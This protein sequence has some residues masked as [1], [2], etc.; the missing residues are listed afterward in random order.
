MSSA[1][2]LVVDDDPDLVDFVSKALEP[3]QLTIE[4]AGSG[5]AALSRV[6]QQAPELML[7][8]LVLPGIDGLETLRQLRREGFEF[9][10]VL[11]TSHGG[12]ETTI[13]AMEEGAWDYL[14]KPLHVAQLTTLVERCLRYTRRPNG[15]GGLSDDV[16]E[17]VLL[18]G[19]AAMVELFK[20][21]GRMAKQDAAVLLIGERGLGKRLVARA[22]HGH[23]GRP[24][25]LLTLDCAAIPETLLEHA[26]FGSDEEQKIGMLERVGQGTLLLEHVGELPPLVQG[27]LLRVLEERAIHRPGSNQPVPLELRI[28]ATTR[29]ELEAQVAKGRFRSDLLARLG[30]VSI[31]I[32]PLRERREDLHLLTDE[33]VR[34]LAPRSGRKL[35]SIEPGFYERLRQYTW[36]GNV[37]ELWDVVE[38]ALSQGAGPVLQASELPDWESSEPLPGAGDKLEA[39]EQ[40]QIAR[41]LQDSGWNQSAAARRLGIHRNTLRRKIREYRLQRPE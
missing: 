1:R 12:M 22:I 27:R 9:P 21:I 41:V 3:L 16:S 38:Q 37:R 18:G 29:E 23:S 31:R 39:L 25:P 20:A 33:C 4:S 10:V 8:D 6:R 5:E 15:M 24:G 17:I 32:P 35:E 30:E 36:P 13:E 34:Q 28:I 19:S 14:A 7:L 26:L 40:S 2:L 11:I